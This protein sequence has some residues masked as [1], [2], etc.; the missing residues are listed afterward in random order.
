[1]TH[2]TGTAEFRPD[3]KEGAGGSEAS[4]E[5]RRSHDFAIRYARDIID[6]AGTVTAIF[7]DDCG[8]LLAESSASSRP[9][10]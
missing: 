8:Y 10:F 6:A 4:E 1:M 7:T 3:E 5:V 9:P 2:S